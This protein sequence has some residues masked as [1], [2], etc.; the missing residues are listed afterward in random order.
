VLENAG[1]ITHP[2]QMV[3][4]YPRQLAGLFVER[5]DGGGFSS[6]ELWS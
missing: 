5:L 1:R 6:H 3:E 2:K 4:L